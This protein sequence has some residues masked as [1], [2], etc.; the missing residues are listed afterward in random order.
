MT[1]NEI[2]RLTLIRQCIDKKM[3]QNQ[4]A[5]L[6][7]LSTRQI[8]RLIRRYEKEGPKGIISQACGKP[9]NRQYADS[10]RKKAVTLIKRDF[11]DYGPTLAAEKLLEYHSIKISKETARQWMI[12]ALVWQAHKKRI[13]KIHPLRERRPCLGE[14]IQIDGSDHDWFEN[15][16][17]RCTLLVSIDDAT[18]NIQKLFFCNANSYLNQIQRLESSRP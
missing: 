18:S 13:P 17:P 15:R 4:T 16:G 5:A 2:D 8:R 12:G 1:N 11:Y 10:L 3:T 9:S 6:L 7:G 14:L